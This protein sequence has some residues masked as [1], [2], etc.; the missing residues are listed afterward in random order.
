VSSSGRGAGRACCCPPG[1]ACLHVPA[2][3][4]CVGGT[5]DLGHGHNTPQWQW[6]TC[7]VLPVPWR[8][9][10]RRACSRS[11]L[12]RPDWW[13]DGASVSGLDALVC[14]ALLR[15]NVHHLRMSWECRGRGCEC[16]EGVDWGDSDQRRDSTT[17]SS[18]VERHAWSPTWSACEETRSRLV[19]SSEPIKVQV[20]VTAHVVRAPCSSAPRGRHRPFC[21]QPCAHALERGTR[22]RVR[23]IGRTAAGL[24]SRRRWPV[25]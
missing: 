18:T 4:E 21:K 17:L 22:R 20:Y 24:T 12:P 1:R 8:S 3:L 5:E 7:S 15:T 6:Q 23:S 2:A 10:A 11:G 19:E 14:L 9:L 25:A 13:W 16:K